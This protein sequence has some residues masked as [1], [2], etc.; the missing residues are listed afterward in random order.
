MGRNIPSTTYRVD[1]KLKKW[2]DF[3]KHLGLI[4]QE[5]FNKLAA[6]ARNM[7]GAIDAANE[8]DIGVAIL[9]AMIVDLKGEL[10]ERSGCE[11]KRAKNWLP[12]S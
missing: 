7:R 11:K 10:D 12:Q 1:V 4:D 9:L 6:S 2:A 3:S 8:A 5:A